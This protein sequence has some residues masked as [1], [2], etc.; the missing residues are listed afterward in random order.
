MQRHLSECEECRGLLAGLRA[1]LA[2]L[3]RLPAP[4]GSAGALE[5]AASVRLQLENDQRPD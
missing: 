2:A 1:M 4:S 3:Q 5:I